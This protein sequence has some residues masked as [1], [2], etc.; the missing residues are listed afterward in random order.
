MLRASD[1][2]CKALTQII[3]E[4]IRRESLGYNHGDGNTG[5]SEKKHSLGVLYLALLV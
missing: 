4:E 3:G 5:T 1:I 2:R